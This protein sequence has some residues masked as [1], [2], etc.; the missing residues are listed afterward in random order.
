MRVI[1]LIERTSG[2]LV[3]VPRFERLL[4]HH[5]PV[6]QA[7]EA[8]ADRG[9]VVHLLCHVQRAPKIAAGL[10]EIA[11]TPEKT[12]RQQALPLGT[13][14]HCGLCNF[15]RP[16]IVLERRIEIAEELVGMAAPLIDG[17]WRVVPQ[18]PDRFDRAG[19]LFRGCMPRI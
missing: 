1:E 15:Q 7:V 11:A 16:R 6:A 3:E 18:V 13:A 12:Q 2:L 4:A 19:K 17:G 10:G 9:L 14:I 5:V 8:V